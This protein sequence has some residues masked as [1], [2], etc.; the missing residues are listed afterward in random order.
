[1]RKIDRRRFLQ[2]AGAAM[3]VGAAGTLTGCGGIV[4]GGDGSTPLTSVTMIK[5][6]QAWQW[7]NHEPKDAFGNSYLQSVNYIVLDVRKMG[8]GWAEESSRKGYQA[9]SSEY[10]T[11]G[12]YDEL[13]MKIAPDQWMG[14]YGTA[15]VQVYADDK[16]VKVSDEIVRKTEPFTLTANISGAKYVKIVV[17][18]YRGFNYVIV[19]GTIDV[20]QGAI[21]IADA[22]LWKK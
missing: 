7:S 12:N 20:E 1:M 16:L 11:N 6:N 18:L 9:F 2:L 3:L 21:I 10:Y 4:P 5:A 13:T 8:A 14:N 15:Y 17:D 22:K 19:N